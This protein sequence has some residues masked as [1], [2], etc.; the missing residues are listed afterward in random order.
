MRG[1]L[2]NSLK[3]TGI[4]T[5]SRYQGSKKIKIK[6]VH[7]AGNTQLYDFLADCFS[8]EM[9]KA[10]PKRPAKIKL[11]NITESGIIE[12]S[13][14]GF[15]GLF[16]QPTVSITESSCKITYSFLI[17]RDQLV[18]LASTS[19]LGLGLYPKSAINIDDDELYNYIASCKLALT[20][21]EIHASS[22]LVVDWELIF[23][24][25]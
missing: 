15:I 16:S 23:S 19:N 3:Y 2:K 8:G 12:A 11:L 25:G 21:S 6:Q 13:S 14:S 22:S 10:L 1:R 18:N 4:V 20:S 17:P 9:E 7:N 5:V 24:N